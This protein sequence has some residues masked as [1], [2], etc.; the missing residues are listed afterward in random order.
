MACSLISDNRGGVT[1]LAM[2]RMGN[3]YIANIGDGKL[4]RLRPDGSDDVILSQFEGRPLGAVNFAYVDSE[5]R[6][7]VPSRQ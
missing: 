6:L 3:L 1:R 4:Y 2:G 7:W 5:A